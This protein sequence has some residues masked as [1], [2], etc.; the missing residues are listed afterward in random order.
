MYIEGI[1]F[2]GGI[3]AHLGYFAVGE[4]HMR[5]VSYIQTAIALLLVSFGILVLSGRTPSEACYNTAYATAFFSAGLYGSLLVYRLLLSPLRRFPGP[6]FAKISSF[7]FAIQAQNGKAHTA[8]CRLHQKYGPFVRVGS[9]DLSVIHPKAV[10]AI[11]GRGS[12][13]IKADWYDMT[14]PRVSL[15]ATRQRELHDQR[16]RNW[17]LAFT[18]ASINS[19]EKRIL[20][21]QEQLIAY[22]DSQKGAPIEA[23][24]LS[25]M[26]S[27]D[28][29]G[30]L[31]FGK[32]FQMLENKQQHKA[33]KSM[34]SAVEPAGLYFPVWFF[35]M[36]LV[37]PGA[38]SVFWEFTRHCREHLEKR[39]HVSGFLLVK[40]TVLFM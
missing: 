1:A 32:S 18:S 29:L 5:A 37:I 19:Y 14:A 36:F 17:N 4:H 26:Y 33:I 28:V 34:H 39:M 31:A 2:G 6:W 23:Q 40:G 12:P 25:D 15:H 24:F 20:K 38:M 11:Y 21:Y 7:D 30:D 13:C 9:S 27:F 8:L 35:R 16:R 10:N 22:I 3:S